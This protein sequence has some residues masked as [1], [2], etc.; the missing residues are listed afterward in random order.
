MAMKRIREK[1]RRWGA[2]ATKN[3]AEQLF[4]RT[5]P[6]TGAELPDGCYRCIL[7][8][9]KP[10]P[11]GV[12]Q[13]SEPWLV[14]SAQKNSLIANLKKHL[15]SYHGIILVLSHFIA[16]VNLTCV[17]FFFFFFSP[18]LCFFTTGHS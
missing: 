6:T 12:K 13:S 18:S 5:H 15:K 1:D 9:P 4:E 8:H 17:F 10:H 7:G 2:E 16:L 11:K 14:K 3:R